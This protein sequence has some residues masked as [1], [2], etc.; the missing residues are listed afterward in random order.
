M[1]I[2]RRFLTWGAFVIVLGAVP[3]AV[4]AGLLD[5]DQVRGWW[6]LWPLIV[7]GI[8]LG[9]VLHRT[10]FEVLGGLLVAVTLGMM[11]GAVLAGGTGGLPNA[12]CGNDRATGTLPAASGTFEGAGSIDLELDCGELQL[13][14]VS[15]SDWSFDGSGDAGRA[16]AIESTSDRL[17]I[18]SHE[19]TGINLVGRRETWNVSVPRDVPVAINLQLNAGRATI[20]PGAA[21]LREVQ[22]QVNF[23]AITLDLGEVTGIDALDIQSNAGTIALTLPNVSHSG[24][25]QVNAGA[26]RLCAPAG[27]ALR[28]E[29]GESAVSSYDFGRAGL[30]QDGS[31]WT[32]PNYDAAAVRI[33]LEAEANAGSFTLNPEEGCNG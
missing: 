26:V 7:V 12:V 21:T 29:T 2:N 28:I 6:S 27:A 23:G 20:A 3:L 15:G 10:S 32:S 31:T 22:A 13:T 24:Q 30:V 16:P 4:R 17:A 9:L 8:G 1:R 33:D 25:I 19:S 5:G 18:R 11:G 14:G